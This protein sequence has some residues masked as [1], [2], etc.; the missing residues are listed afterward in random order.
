MTLKL[1][2]QGQAVENGTHSEK[3]IKGFMQKRI[4]SFA[5]N[6]RKRKKRSR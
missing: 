2:K 5:K 4:N 3:K 6:R 1:K